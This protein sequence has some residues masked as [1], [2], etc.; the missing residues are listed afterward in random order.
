MPLPKV[1]TV[2]ETEDSMAEPTLIRGGVVLP[3]AAGCPLPTPK[4]CVAGAGPPP[5]SRPPAVHP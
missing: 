4:M 1:E 3:M 2:R 5:K